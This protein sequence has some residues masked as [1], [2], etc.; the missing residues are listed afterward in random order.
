MKPFQLINL[1]SWAISACTASFN[2]SISSVNN[3]FFFKKFIDYTEGKLKCARFITA[4]K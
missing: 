2:N 1:R 4:P 3:F